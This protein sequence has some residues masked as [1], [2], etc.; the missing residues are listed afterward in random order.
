MARPS[1]SPPRRRVVV[2]SACRKRSK[3]NGRNSGRI[4]SP[5]IAH[6]GFDVPDHADQD[7]FDA[8]PAGVNF[9]AL[10]AVPAAF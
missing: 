10:L 6:A 7:H 5:R 4:P 2:E 3:T 8:A 9:T 1:P